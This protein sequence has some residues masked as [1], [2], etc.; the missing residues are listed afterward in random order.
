[1]AKAKAK[2]TKKPSLMFHVSGDDDGFVAGNMAENASAECTRIVRELTQNALDAVREA[3]RDYT[4]VRFGL[5]E[6]KVSKIPS[7]KE[8]K[9]AFNLAKDLHRSMSSDDE[10]TGSHEKVIRDIDE[11]LK[12]KDV[13]VLF[14]TDNGIGLTG[15]RMKSILSDGSTTKVRGTAGSFGVGH[16]TAFPA[17]NLRYLFYGGVSEDDGAIAAGQCILASFEKNGKGM[18]KNGYFVTRY[19]DNPRDRFDFAKGKQIPSLI[20]DRINHIKKDGGG[21]GTG[22]VVVIPAFNFFGGDKAE[23]WSNIK[24]AVATNFFAAI[25]KGE[26]VVEFTDKV[27]KT[28]RLDA[29]NIR[30]EFENFKSETQSK[31]QFLSGMRA[32]AAYEAVCKGKDVFV[33]FGKEKIRIR[34]NKTGVEGSKRIVL[35]RNGMWITNNLL[36]LRPSA[37]FGDYENF[38]AAILLDR[39]QRETHDLIRDAEGPSHKEI[40]LNRLDKKDKKKLRDFVTAIKNCL[41]DVLKRQDSPIYESDFWHI[42]GTHTADFRRVTASPKARQMMGGGG[43]GS[44]TSKKSKGKK[45]GGVTPGSKPGKT[46]QFTATPV[47]RGQ[48]EC[49]VE[50]TPSINIDKAEIRFTLDESYD[51]ASTLHNP[52]V[53]VK[54]KDV[55]IDGQKAKQGDLTKDTLGI[56][57]NQ[58][59]KGN[60]RKIEFTFEVPNEKKGGEMVALKAHLFKPDNSATG[61]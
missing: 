28:Y 40:D 36:S 12:S 56:R 8:Y 13:D 3:D 43:S 58:L 35:C 10:L 53:F 55:Y 44:G 2:V 57:L 23:L 49:V 7:I 48:H 17:S 33:A 16:L 47:M 54:L 30:E 25:A 18:G 59:V 41:K 11:A 45:Q 26:L 39:D 32:F 19:G 21:K 52:E 34:L 5:A 4:V 42:G 6:I 22:S 46:M 60:R 31:S 24:K 20:A 37:D 15:K 9:K 50:I 61:E 27:G 29:S 38:D 14:V 51:A 1:M